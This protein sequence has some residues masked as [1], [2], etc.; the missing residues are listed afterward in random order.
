MFSKRPDISDVNIPIPSAA[1]VC[2]LD[3]IR[4]VMSVPYDAQESLSS[5]CTPTLSYSLLFYHLI[6]DDWENLK[7]DYPLLSPFIGIGVN[8]VDAYINKS[9]LSRTYSLATRLSLHLPK[10]TYILM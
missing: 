4:T 3:H 2:V 8:K 6:I 1:E 10:V 7:E 5:D 9:K